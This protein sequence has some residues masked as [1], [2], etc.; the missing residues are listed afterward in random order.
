ME[1]RFLI[2]LF[3]MFECSFSQTV[4]GRVHAMQLILGKI[5]ASHAC[6]AL[7][8]SLGLSVIGL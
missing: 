5:S 7:V 1:D 6:K 8:N 4:T 2:F 3:T